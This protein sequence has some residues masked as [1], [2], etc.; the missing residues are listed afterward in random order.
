M[1]DVGGG[2]MVGL[3]NR[4]CWCACRWVTRCPEPISCAA[5]T[6]IP[7]QDKGCATRNNT[8]T[9]FTTY[10][11]ATTPSGSLLVKL[12]NMVPMRIAVNNSDSQL[13]ILGVPHDSTLAP[14]FFLFY[15]NSLSSNY[16]RKFIF[17]LTNFLKC[18]II[19]NRNA[20]PYQ[21]TRSSILQ[22]G[23]IIADLFGSGCNSFDTGTRCQRFDT[24]LR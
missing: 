8:R 1:V 14:S 13:I 6:W 9:G 5:R 11:I 19:L 7:A 10:F 18:I 3:V 2:A 22:Y 4:V 15:C 20:I 16:T 21:P 24:Y 17:I 23:L 12:R